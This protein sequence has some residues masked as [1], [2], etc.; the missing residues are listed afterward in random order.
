MSKAT[1]RKTSSTARKRKGNIKIKQKAAIKKK[2]SRDTT[3]TKLPQKTTILDNGATFKIVL[4][5]K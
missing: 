4:R 2:E 1:P 3:N 5:R